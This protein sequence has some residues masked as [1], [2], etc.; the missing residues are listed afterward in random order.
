MIFLLVGPSPARSA[1]INN[2]KG[3]RP[4]ARVHCVGGQLSGPEW[5]RW[6]EGCL[7]PLWGGEPERKRLALSSASSPQPRQPLRGHVHHLLESPGKETTY[8]LGSRSKQTGG[9]QKICPFNIGCQQT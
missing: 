3:V 7:T 1:A 4:L 5:A 8:L 9:Q 6:V 2:Y